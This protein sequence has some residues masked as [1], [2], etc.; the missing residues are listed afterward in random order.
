M[1]E[2]HT[3]SVEKRKTAKIAENPQRAQRKSLRT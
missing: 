3:L 2:I 1:I